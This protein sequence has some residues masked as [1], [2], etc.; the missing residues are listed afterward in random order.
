VDIP[1]AIKAGWNT[2]I[3]KTNHGNRAFT[4][5]R[6]SAKIGD[7]NGLRR[8]DITFSTR[9]INL[10]IT[11]ASAGVYN[12]SWSHPDFHG[13]QVDSYKLDVATSPNF[14]TLVEDNKDLGVITQTTVSG[15]EDGRK[16]FFRIKPFN[17]SALGG[18]VYWH[19][20][21]V[22]SSDGLVS[23]KEVMRK[24]TS[25]VSGVKVLN[26][27]KQLL[28][29]IP[30]S[31][32]LKSLSIVNLHGVVADKFNIQKQNKGIL[33]DWSN[34]VVAAGLYFAV[35]NYGELKT[36]IAFVVN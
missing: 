6:F 12:L 34:S 5:W 15:L 19:H 25:R 18:S 9:D 4:G 8:S 7:A 17:S 21:D 11:K 36:R 20:V 26:Y 31:D 24:Y 30:E 27:G 13:S 29:R 14:L 28:M 22:V 35:L 1:L 2:L 3:T 10:K 32:N 33:I 23:N 16:Y